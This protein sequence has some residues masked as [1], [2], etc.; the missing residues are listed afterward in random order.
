MYIITGFE[1][2]NNKKVVNT[3]KEL[4]KEAKKILKQNKHLGFDNN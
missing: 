2:D 1:Y 4:I 3:N